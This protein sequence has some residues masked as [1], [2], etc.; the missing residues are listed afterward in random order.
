MAIPHYNIVIC[1]PGDMVFNTYNQSLLRTIQYLNSQ[2][3]TWTWMNESSPH[4]AKTRAL[5]LNHGYAGNDGFGE[6]P[7]EYKVKDWQVFSGQFTYDQIVWIDN[8]ISWKIE[9]FVR[10]INHQEEVV[11]GVYMFG[12]STKHV[13]I[14]MEP[15]TVLHI[16]DLAAMN[17]NE[18][19]EVHTCGMGFL[20]VRYGVTEQ[21]QHPIFLVR[22]YDYFNKKINQMISYKTT[23]EDTS[24]CHRVRESGRRV[25][26][27]PKIRVNHYKRI[28]LVPP[29]QT[30]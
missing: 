12:D 6:F 30:C 27:D 17:Q 20:K 24:F 22:D 23:D 7:H 10:L 26:F 5:I 28:L 19:H 25:F 29:E 13:V 18:L 9:D 1:T 4:I 2:N 15:G 11:S 16:D 21:L 3:I 14:S 8:D